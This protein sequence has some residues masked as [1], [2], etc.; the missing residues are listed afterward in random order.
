MKMDDA[1]TTYSST[2]VKYL[3]NAEEKMYGIDTKIKQLLQKLN[4]SP[5]K[6]GVLVLL[7]FLMIMYLLIY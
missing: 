3:D 2:K 6:H 1:M 4:I 7:Y 5:K